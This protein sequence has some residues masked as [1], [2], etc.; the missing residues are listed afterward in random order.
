MTEPLGPAQARDNGAAMHL[1]LSSRR[2]I[3]EI[4]DEP[5][6]ELDGLPAA[7]AEGAGAG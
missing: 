7:A 1:S 5:D 4:I 2:R 6:L 3:L